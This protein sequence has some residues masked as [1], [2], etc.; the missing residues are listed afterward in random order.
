MYGSGIGSLTT[1]SPVLG[2]CISS[3]TFPLVSN[4]TY[5]SSLFSCCFKANYHTQHSSNSQLGD[6]KFSYIN[7]SLFCISYKKHLRH[8]SYSR[9]LCKLPQ[10]QL[11][12]IS[13][14]LDSFL[15]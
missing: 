15:S 14:C 10:P 8:P 13:S 3:C 9:T 6:Q 1:S 7:S 12:T 11:L 2:S 4:I 5:I